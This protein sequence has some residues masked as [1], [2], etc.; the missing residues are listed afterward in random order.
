M[1]APERRAIAPEQP[2]IVP[3]RPKNALSAQPENAEPNN[4]THE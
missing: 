4:T 2:A 3:E 1:I